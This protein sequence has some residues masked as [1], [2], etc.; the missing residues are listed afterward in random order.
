MS[1]IRHIYIYAHILSPAGQADQRR[2]G[3]LG[4]LVESFALAALRYDGAN[5]HGHGSGPLDGWLIA[6]IFSHPLY[7]ARLQRESSVHSWDSARQR[8][9]HFTI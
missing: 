8:A 4:E 6:G 7:F 5:V 1:N 3:R 2:E 9:L